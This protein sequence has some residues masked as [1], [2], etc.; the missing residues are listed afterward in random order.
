MS[1]AP[2]AAIRSSTAWPAAYARSN[3]QQ[4][5]EAI[6]NLGFNCAGRRH[7]VQHRL[8]SGIHEKQSTTDTGS[9]RKLRVQ[10]RRPPPSGPAPPGQRHTREAIDNLRFY[11]GSSTAWPVTR[12][13]SD[14][15]VAR[16]ASD[17]GSDRK[18]TV[19]LRWP[20]PAGPAI[21]S[22]TVRRSDWRHPPPPR[23]R[24][25]LAAAAASSLPDGRGS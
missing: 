5:R 20:P 22:R 24:P 23:S 9:N 16:G 18:R 1:R 19:Q 10:L 6:E 25:S 7:Q 3:R 15:P 4:T 13:A 11:A 12:G 14:T 8:A 21:R 17:T 2:A